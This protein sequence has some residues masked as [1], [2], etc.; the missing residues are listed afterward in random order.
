MVAIDQ[1]E[2]E[3]REGDGGDRGAEYHPEGE[4]YHSGP[5]GGGHVVGIGNGGDSGQGSSADADVDD[6]DGSGY[7]N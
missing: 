1:A 7:S 2:L 6:D 3:S 5:F 4:E